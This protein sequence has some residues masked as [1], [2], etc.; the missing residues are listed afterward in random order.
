MRS[1]HTE[2]FCKKGLR[3]A[4]SLKKRLWHRCFPVNFAK[5]LRTPFLKE[6]LRW[7]LLEF[8]YSTVLQLSTSRQIKCKMKLDKAVALRC[9]VK[10]SFSNI[11]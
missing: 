1:S 6:H 5:F 3:P 11:Y 10:K 8:L 4:T 9:S 7:L 2:V